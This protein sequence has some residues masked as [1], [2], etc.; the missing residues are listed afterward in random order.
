MVLILF[1][2]LLS[3]D[4]AEETGGQIV[5]LPVVL[6]APFEGSKA[7]I[8]CWS[9]AI[10]QGVSGMLIESLGNSD[11][12]FQLLAAS[13]AS[14]QQ[15]GIPAGSSGSGDG[16][17]PSK[18][19]AGGSAKPATGSGDN[20]QIPDAGSSSGSD[21]ILYGSVVEFAVQTN[22]SKIGDFISSSP[23]AGLGAK[24]VTAHVQVDWRLVDADTKRVITRN[25][26]AGSAH[27]SEFDMTALA[28]T[29]GNSPVAGTAAAQAGA[30]KVPPGG[31][32]GANGLASVNNIF[33]GLNK[34]WGGSPAAGAGAGESVK[35]SSGAAATS[36]NT[37]PKAG[38]DVVADESQ[39][40]GY[41]NSAFMHSALG[42]A[43][44][45]AVTNL[46]EQLAGV[47][48]PE[49]GRAAKLRT[50]TDALKH[51]PGKV[52]AV[53][54]K[55]TIIVSLGSREGFKAGD[56]LEL[57]QA[58]DVKDDKGNV[59]F[60]DEKWVGEITLS[61]VQEDRSRGSYSGDA[62]VQQGWTVKA[63]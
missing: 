6:V 49:P 24:V 2:G 1:S 45:E 35:G 62:Q 30:A 13:N 61:E 58:N 52:L 41:D 47:S 59:V 51:I 43:A 5:S 48:L 60:T 25:S 55:D 63:K 15:N 3:S 31:S 46:M 56:Q 39:A 40:I 32:G 42:R 37:P 50:A 9:P 44:A 34:A 7:Q 21:F 16:T 26:A 11:K 28:A 20:S 53:A 17:K 57:Y 36:P 23:F 38:G 18:G 14:G 12:R 19:A 33:S 27:G 4:C 10:G 22:S 8:P 29:G 54:G